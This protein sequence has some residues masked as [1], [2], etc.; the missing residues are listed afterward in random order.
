M[1]YTGRVIGDTIRCVDWTWIN[2][3]SKGA[4][5]DMLRHKGFFLFVIFAGHGLD[6]DIDCMMTAHG[7]CVADTVTPVIFGGNNANNGGRIYI[8]V[9]VLMVAVLRCNGHLEQVIGIVHV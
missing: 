5:F 6:H 9:A 7:G 4:L 1:N 3:D 8:A 2:E